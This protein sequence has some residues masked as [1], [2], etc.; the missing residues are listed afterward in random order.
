MVLHSIGSPLLW[1]GFTIFVILMM[2][3]DLGVFHRRPHAMGMREAVV[4]TFVW[5]ALALVFNLVVYWL[6]GTERALEFLAGYVIERAL[7]VDNLFVFLVIFSYFAVP[8]KVQHRVLLWGVVG[9]L[10]M[11]AIFILV[12]AALMQAFHWVIYVFGAFLIYTGIKLLFASG[13]EVHPERNPIL[14]LCRRFFRVT[15]DY[16]GARFFVKENGL[17]LATPLLLVLLVVEGTDVIFAVDSIPAVL[18]VTTD[19]FIVYTSNIFAVLGLRAMFFVLAPMMDRF[20]YLKYA[21]GIV[22][23]FVGVKM[24]GTDFFKIPIVWSLIIITALICASI[25]A[26]FI[27]PREVK[28][29][30]E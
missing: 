10:L 7:S 9:A 6:F 14:R 29:K 21:L 24:L 5:I 12:G 3:L 11:R 1:A 20:Y 13:S 4:W 2:V 19:P 28:A 25:L 17:L 15:K 22:L 23:A 18:A 26:S 30:S 27:W 8:P 16:H